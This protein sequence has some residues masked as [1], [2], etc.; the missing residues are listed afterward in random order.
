[1]EEYI[2]E[3]I[4]DINSRGKVEGIESKAA[5]G[6]QFFCTLSEMFGYAIDR[7]LIRKAGELIPWNFP[8]TMSFLAA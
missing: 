5:A 4:G 2:G 7:V 8:I 3:V 6:H 1:M